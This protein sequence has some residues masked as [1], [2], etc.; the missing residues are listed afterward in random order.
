MRYVVRKK[1]VDFLTVVVSIC[2]MS[3]VMTDPTIVGGKDFLIALFPVLFVM[4][5]SLCALAFDNT[6][7][8]F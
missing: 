6:E 7:R 8:R 1:G 3:A 5:M 4:M 2:G